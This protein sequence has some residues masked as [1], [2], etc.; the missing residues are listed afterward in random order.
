MGDVV[1]FN[2]P[3]RGSRIKDNTC[4]PGK[5]MRGTLERTGGRFPSVCCVASMYVYRCASRKRYKILYNRSM[6]GS[7]ALRLLTGATISRMRTNTSVMTPSSVVSK[8]MHTVHRTLS[9]GKRCKTPVVSCTMG[10]T[11]TFCKPFHSTTNSTPSFNSEGDCRVSFRGEER[12]VGRTL[13]S[14]RRNTSVVV[15][16]PTVSCLSVISRMSGTMGIPITACDMD[17]RCTVIGTTTGVK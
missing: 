12:K 5:V 11:S 17:N 13:A 2:V 4:S 6:G 10:C 1:L 9:T 7:T 14:I 16:G 15:M 3:S 8:H